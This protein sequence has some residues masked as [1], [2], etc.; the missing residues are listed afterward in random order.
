MVRQEPSASLTDLLTKFSEA[1]NSSPY[2]CRLSS[3]LINLCS[4][5][6]VLASELPFEDGECEFIST[7]LTSN[8]E[9]SSGALLCIP[10]HDGI[11][12]SDGW[13]NDDT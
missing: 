13:V 1:I 2:L 7:W 9:D 11:D 8:R 12:A 6:S 5:G 4:S 3:R 10:L